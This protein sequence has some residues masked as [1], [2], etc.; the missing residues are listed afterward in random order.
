MKTKKYSCQECSIEFY[1]GYKQSRIRKFCS[2]ACAGAF[3]GK[4]KIKPK[5]NNSECA[6]CKKQFYRQKANQKSKSGLYFCNK[7][8]KNFGQKISS[9][10]VE[11]QPD[12]YGTGTSN[13]SKIAKENLELKCSKCGYDKYKQVLHVHHKD[14]NR[15]NN[16][17]NNLQILCP[18]CHE[19]EHFLRKDGK[20]SKR[21]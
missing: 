7:Q 6:Y 16:N 20:Y 14:R 10:L 12:H 9:G 4:K 11:I 13:Y 1:S 17:L 19:E 3:N 8:C 5:L 21:K 2:L 18:T 15:K